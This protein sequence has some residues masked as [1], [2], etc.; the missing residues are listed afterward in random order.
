[1]LSHPHETVM[2][3]EKL[4][5]LECDSTHFAFLLALINKPRK[6][7]P[8]PCQEVAGAR[9]DVNAHHFIHVPDV[10]QKAADQRLDGR[11][12]SAMPQF[13]GARR[14]PDL[15]EYSTVSSDSLRAVSNTMTPRTYLYPPTFKSSKDAQLLS[16]SPCP[17]IR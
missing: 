8:Y 1:M 9:P 17:S 5:N 15:A 7:A 13:V 11:N 14:C 10:F 6:G 2:H 12:A 4:V 16:W 3:V